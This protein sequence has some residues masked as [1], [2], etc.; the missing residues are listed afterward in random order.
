MGHTSQNASA[1]QLPTTPPTRGPL[2]EAE[3]VVDDQIF[4]G[5]ANS[6]TLNQG[7]RTPTLEMVS[8]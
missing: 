7:R 2:V 4:A 5:I 3:C 1:L 8:P 6:A